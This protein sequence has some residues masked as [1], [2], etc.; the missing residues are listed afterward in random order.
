MNRCKDCVWWS[1]YDRSWANNPGQEAGGYC[2]HGKIE[3]SPVV[4]RP[5]ALCYSYNE[6]GAFWT[7]PEF[8]CVHWEKR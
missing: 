7:G 2:N 8:G 4:Y 3:E 6:G 1:K 5:D